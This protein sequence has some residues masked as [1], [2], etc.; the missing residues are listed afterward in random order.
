MINVKFP[1]GEWYPIHTDTIPYGKRQTHAMKVPGG[2]V[3][4]TTI[5]M[6][7]SNPKHTEST[8]FIPGSGI[9][10]DKT[11]PTEWALCLEIKNE[12]AE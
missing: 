8:V 10:S 7:V 6:D 12:V 9:K 3:L 5:L 1:G 11:R 4:R 2:V